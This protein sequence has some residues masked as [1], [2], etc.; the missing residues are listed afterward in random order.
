MPTTDVIVWAAIAGLIVLMLGIIGYL[1]RSGFEGIK[2]E[3]QKLWDKLDNQQIAAVAAATQLASMEAR[4]E[5]RHR[6][7]SPVNNQGQQ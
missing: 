5:E 2:A 3:L 4:C 6:H 1:I 7:V